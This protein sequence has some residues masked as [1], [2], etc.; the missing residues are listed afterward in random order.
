MRS[1]LGIFGRYGGRCGKV[2]FGPEP[3]PWD[4]G[5]RADSACKW[6]EA[7]VR[8]GDDQAEQTG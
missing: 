8:G 6:A 3:C 4:G 2:R 1:S 7:V 5:A